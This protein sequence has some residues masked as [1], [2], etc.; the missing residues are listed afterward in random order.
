M[1]REIKLCQNNVLPH[2]TVKN[3]KAGL[4]ESKNN[5]ANVYPK[6]YK[7]NGYECVN[8]MQKC[9]PTKKSWTP[10]PLN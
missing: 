3:Q 8:M 10:C 1:E 9:F 2:K 6:K 5:I 4:Q 7:T